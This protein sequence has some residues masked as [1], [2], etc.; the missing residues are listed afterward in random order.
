MSNR[1]GA[2]S[3]LAPSVRQRSGVVAAA[4]VWAE[5]QGAP[6]AERSCMCLARRRFSGFPLDVWQVVHQG[7][8]AALIG[9]A[10]TGRLVVHNGADELEWPGHENRPSHREN[11]KKSARRSSS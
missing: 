5:V 2:Q 11:F 1:R 4:G 6:D 8:R 10:V 3:R 9:A 7:A